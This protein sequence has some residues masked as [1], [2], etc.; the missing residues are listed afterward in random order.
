MDN[1]LKKVLDINIYRTKQ[2]IVC[3][4]PLEKE[5]SDREK[6]SSYF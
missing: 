6:K 1:S 5:I 3:R 4:Y 2:G